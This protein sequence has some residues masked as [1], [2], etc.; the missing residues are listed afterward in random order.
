[1]LFYRNS[2][3]L[4]NEFGSLV[5]DGVIQKCLCRS[6]ERGIFF[7]DKDK[8]TLDF[9]GAV[10]YSFF[11][12]GY[13]VNGD[14]LH[15]LI[16]RSKG[17]I[18]KRICICCNTCNDCTGAGQLLF[19]LAGILDIDNAFETV[20]GTRTCFTSDEYDGCIVAADF[21]PVADGAGCQA[22]ICSKDKSCT[23]FS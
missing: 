8:G 4:G 21:L 11:R 22:W 1:M 3:C 9:I 17:S 15:R 20:T 2:A 16:Y 13:S 18:A 14:C 7:G 6:T 23:G 12:S 19:I 5:A 10:L